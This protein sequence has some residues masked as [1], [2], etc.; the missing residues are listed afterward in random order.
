MKHGEKPLAKG[1]AGL[2]HNDNSPYNGHRNDDLQKAL[3]QL[4][5]HFYWALRDAI[6]VYGFSFGPV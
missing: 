6:A 3:V 4:C 1:V 2:H 5:F